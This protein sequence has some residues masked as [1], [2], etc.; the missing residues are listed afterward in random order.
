[1]HLHCIPSGLLHIRMDYIALHYIYCIN[2]GLE[3]ANLK[4]F[5]YCYLLINKLN[6]GFFQVFA[7]FFATHKSQVK[8]KTKL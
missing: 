2:P 1:M 5:L 4:M 3:H 8:L 6:K 7:V